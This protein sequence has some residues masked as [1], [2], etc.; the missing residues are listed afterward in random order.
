MFVI[1]YVGGG[2]GRKG[3]GVEMNTVFMMI[4]YH[5]GNSLPCDTAIG[6]PIS[7]RGQGMAK[8]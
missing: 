6:I 1:V 2:G 5:V 7:P 8:K 3:K 4:A